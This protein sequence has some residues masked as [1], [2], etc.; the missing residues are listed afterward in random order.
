M[1]QGWVARSL[2]HVPHLTVLT[3]T[4]GNPDGMFLRS[5]IGGLRGYKPAGL[6]IKSRAMQKSPLARAFL[7]IQL[8]NRL[9]CLDIGSLLALGTLNDVEGDLL[10]F[11]EG[12]E[13]AHVDCG[14]VREQVFATIIRSDEAKTFC[15][16]EPLYSTVCHVTSLY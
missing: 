16:V 14:E 10:A 13:T 8:R 2:C 11:L 3:L 5:R 9:R 6:S 15:I 12:F 1:A 7:F 4:P